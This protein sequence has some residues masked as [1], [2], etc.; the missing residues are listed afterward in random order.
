VCHNKI[1]IDITLGNRWNTNKIKSIPGLSKKLNI[2][3]PLFRD[4]YR[5]YSDHLGLKSSLL[6]RSLEFYGSIAYTVLRDS[7]IRINLHVGDVV[8]IE[9]E[10][11][12]TAYARIKLI[13]RH[14][15]NN[16]QYY[17]FFVL[18]WFEATNTVDTILDCP[19]YKIQKPE[20]TRWVQI[21]TIDFVY[22]IPCVHF[23]H[24]CTN[25]CNS[26]HDETNRNYILNSFYYNAV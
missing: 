19:L 22:R 11:E 15:A 23:I 20:E 3:N 5:A 4:L 1:F 21:F 17:A 8:E 18:E 12:G 26:E 25:T 9:E 2:N 14:K 6:N 16:A 13:V 7:P 10:S 24:N